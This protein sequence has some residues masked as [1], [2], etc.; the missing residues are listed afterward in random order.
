MTEEERG[1]EMR[2]T[3]EEDRQTERS[4]R[5]G[6]PGTTQVHEKVHA[7][8]AEEAPT[9]D[10]PAREPTEKIERMENAAMEAE[11]RK[12]GEETP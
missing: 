6:P 1:D 3:P 4:P 12:S 9:E 11:R 10:S 7:T 8:P 5:I 2:R